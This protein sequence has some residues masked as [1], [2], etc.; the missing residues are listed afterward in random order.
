MVR[1]ETDVLKGMVDT[2]SESM[3]RRGGVWVA[4]GDRVGVGQSISVA[5]M[6]AWSKDVEKRGAREATH[7]Y[8]RLRQRTRESHG[9]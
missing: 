3:V 1:P 9:S 4:V 7:T 2:Q 8:T 6:T 5:S